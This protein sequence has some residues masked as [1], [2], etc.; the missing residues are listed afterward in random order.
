MATDLAANRYA[1][2]SIQHSNLSAQ[3]GLQRLTAFAFLVLGTGPFVRSRPGH[4]T[5]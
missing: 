2:Y 1:V 5:I 3:P 4:S